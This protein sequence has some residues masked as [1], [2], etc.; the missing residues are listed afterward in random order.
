MEWRERTASMA[1]VALIHVA[2]AYLF[3]AGLAYRFIPSPENALRVFAVNVPPPPLPE[4]ERPRSARPEREGAAAPEGRK[5]RASPV[6]SLPSPVERP[7]PVTA[8]PIPRDGSE[9]SAGAAERGVGPGSG[10]TGAGTGSGGQGAGSGGGGGARA[11]QIDGRIRH[12]D[13]P[14]GAL[15]D[16]IG[17]TVRVRYTVGIDGRPRNCVVERWTGSIELATTTCRLIERRFRY[18]P[19]LNAAGE[20][21]PSEVGWEQIWWLE[22]GRD[23]S[24]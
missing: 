19:A 6:V 4:P 9:S 1:A 12:R 10:G 7:Q 22:N 3:I 13:Y 24:D 14:P 8:A 21:I 20:P 23:D 2:V 11:R 5:A 16:R 15:R 18:R 17:G